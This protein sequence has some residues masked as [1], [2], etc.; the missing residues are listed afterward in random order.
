MNRELKQLEAKETNPSLLYVRK[1]RGR[2]VNEESCTPHYTAFSRPNQCAWYNPKPKNHSSPS[3]PVS[4]S[5]PASISSIS[6]QSGLELDTNHGDMIDETTQTLNQTL[7]TSNQ[8]ST[9]TNKDSMDHPQQYLQLITNPRCKIACHTKYYK[10]EVK[11][12]KTD[13]PRD[14]TA[15]PIATFD[16]TKQRITDIDKLSHSTKIHNKVL[17]AMNLNGLCKYDIPQHTCLN[18]Q[19]NQSTAPTY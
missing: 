9:Y 16:E 10:H 18:T 7:M 1:L 3:T 17:Q 15:P 13:S 12:L 8:H 6:P 2:N 14:N 5:T 19:T 4:Q 11:R